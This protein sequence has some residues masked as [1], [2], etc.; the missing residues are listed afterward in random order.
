MSVMNEDLAHFRRFLV[1]GSES[2]YRVGSV[3]KTCQEIVPSCLER[4]LQAGHGEEVVR[5]ITSRQAVP[6]IRNTPCLLS[7]AVCARS[8]C[9][10]TKR[11]AF[12]AV[13]QVCETPV[14]LFTFIQYAKNTS[15]TRKGWGRALRRT[16]SDW[17]NKKDA[18][19]LAEL[20][21]RFKSSCGWTHLDVLRLSHTKPENADV[22]IVL[23]YL[24]R[25]LSA[26]KEAGNE[27]MADLLKY[28]EAVD[29]VK[30]SCDEHQVAIL[31]REHGLCK[32][33]IPTKLLNSSE[34]WIALIENMT[35]G[36]V[37]M[38]ISKIA[39]LNLLDGSCAASQIILNKLQ[40][41]QALITNRVSPM[42]VLIAL[43]TYEQGKGKG[44]WIRNEAVV[45]ALN[46]AFGTAISLNAGWSG[47]RILVGVKISTNLQRSS[48]RGTLVLSPVIAVAGLIQILL[49]T[50]ADC[51]LVYF[52]SDVKQLTVSPQMSL[53]DICKEVAKASVPLPPQLCQC[54]MAA[55]IRWAEE[56]KQQYDVMIILTD[57]KESTGEM[58]TAQAIS[59]Y[60]Q[61]LNLQTKLAICGLTA[62]RLNQADQTDL[63]SLDIAGFDASV[64]EVLNSF[65]AGLF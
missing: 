64:P 31:I 65:A 28:L 49:H 54:D 21:T 35:V 43:R 36:H 27:D 53:A 22:G 14:Q 52:L 23:K 16:V 45:S 37:L 11:A 47:K 25:G 7:L 38:N 46:K 61:S 13:N 56:N 9:A 34:V 41:E 17:Y 5:E 18:K 40:D 19:T 3:D 8:V 30:H 26:A 15:E 6:N 32:E 50:K 59:Q 4:L 58:T 44:K 29:T 62:S 48:V 42:M 24:L 10:H 60:R 1:I 12:N 55:P 33:Q 39:S 57:S 51:Q 63:G 2:L 20:T